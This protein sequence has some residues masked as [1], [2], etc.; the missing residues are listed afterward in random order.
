[1]AVGGQKFSQSCMLRGCAEPVHLFLDVNN[2][3][4]VLNT[5]GRKETFSDMSMLTNRCKEK[6]AAFFSSPQLQQDCP[7]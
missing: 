1:M 5:W 2:G 4:T 6:Q 7:C 3:I